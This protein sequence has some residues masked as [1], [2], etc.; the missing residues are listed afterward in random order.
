MNKTGCLL[1]APNP[2]EL[3][4]LAP[5]ATALPHASA[6]PLIRRTLKAKLLILL[7][8]D[9]THIMHAEAM[10]KAETGSHGHGSLK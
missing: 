10:M 6:L 3:E 5:P 4:L 7:I 2:L 8:S 9:S 1:Y